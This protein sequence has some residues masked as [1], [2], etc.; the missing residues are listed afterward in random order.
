MTSKLGS[1]ATPLGGDSAYKEHGVSLIRSLN[2]HDRVFVRKNLAFIDEH[3]ASKLK[4][5]IVEENDV[6]LN[7]TGAS[8]ARVCRVPANVLPARVNQHVMI[9]RPTAELNSVYLESLL[10]NPS[11]KAKLLRVGGA[12]ATRE[13]IT[14]SEV[15]ELEIVVPP[16]RLQE[17]F[18]LRMESLDYLRR[19]GESE[20]MGF[21][22]L[23]K[24]LQHLEFQGVL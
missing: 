3:Q 6:L 16:K 20:L 9:I 18:K 10:L 19:K 7:I 8:V 5:V 24:S 21:E 22:K 13:A 14:K 1:G 11:M 17:E 15:E 2:V 23:F 4:N 12:G